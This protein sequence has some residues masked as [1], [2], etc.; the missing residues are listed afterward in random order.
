MD[1]A[2]CTRPPYIYRRGCCTCRRVIIMGGNRRSF[3]SL[4]LVEFICCWF[5]SN[6]FRIR[7]IL[8]IGCDARLEKYIIEEIYVY[9][10][11]G[12]YIY[13]ASWRYNTYSRGTAG[14]IRYSKSQ[15]RPLLRRWELEEREREMDCNLVA[16]AWT[17]E[18]TI[19]ASLLRHFLFFLE[20]EWRRERMVSIYFS[21]CINI[22][23][24]CHFDDVHNG[25]MLF[26]RGEYSLYTLDIRRWKFHF[27][28]LVLIICTSCWLGESSWKFYSGIYRKFTNVTL[29]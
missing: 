12:L 13:K 3:L 2:C 19:I 17:R 10:P 22:Y 15:W 18:E 23:I 28:S 29:F 24:S 6:K 16:R 11:W 25:C 7:V 14:C 9:V 5:F 20:F 21:S 4:T 8:P 27:E 26:Y 1:Y